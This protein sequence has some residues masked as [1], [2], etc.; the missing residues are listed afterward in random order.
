MTDLSIEVRGSD[1]VIR[2]PLAGLSITYRRTADEPLLVATDLM[3]RD[4]NPAETEFLVQAWKAA[5]KKA[6]ELGWL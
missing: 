1:I 6:K 5:Q 3:R 4:P 2:K